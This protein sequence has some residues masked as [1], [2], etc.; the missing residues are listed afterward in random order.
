MQGA[1]EHSGSAGGAA[2]TNS[3]VR[4]I[5]WGG[6]SPARML[7]G[8]V[9]EASTSELFETSAA[10]MRPTCG[11]AGTASV[12]MYGLAQRTCR[13]GKS[14]FMFHEGM[15]SPFFHRRPPTT[16]LASLKSARDFH[17]LQ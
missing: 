7:T 16:P 1:E 2:G 5:G 10:E 3:G 12:L 13:C 11:T 4:A 9:G 8:Q 14:R 6:C 15:G 17:L